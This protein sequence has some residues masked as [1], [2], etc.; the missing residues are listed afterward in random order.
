MLLLLSV[1][2]D[3]RTATSKD[4]FCPSMGFL[5]GLKCC[6]SMADVLEDR[7]AQMLSAPL[8]IPCKMRN[9]PLDIVLAS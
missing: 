8:F 5:V 6:P 2:P 7:C 4:C 3:E 9:E 1:S